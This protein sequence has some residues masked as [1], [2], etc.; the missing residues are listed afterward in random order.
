[1]N[2]IRKQ[3]RA[4]TTGLRFRLKVA[5]MLLGIYAAIHLAVGGVVYLLQ[6]P[7]A[8]AAVTIDRPSSCAETTMPASRPREGAGAARDSR[9][10]PATQRQARALHCG[11]GTPMESDCPAG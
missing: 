5:A 9:E 6:A 11:Q 4:D 8:Y 3:R 2:T 1:M 10:S 7:D